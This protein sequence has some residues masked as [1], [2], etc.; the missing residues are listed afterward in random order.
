MSVASVDV[1]FVDSTGEGSTV[2]GYG[3]GGGARESEFAEYLNK[4][5]NQMEMYIVV[6]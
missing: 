5:H 6:I 3:D 2:A 1:E 4:K